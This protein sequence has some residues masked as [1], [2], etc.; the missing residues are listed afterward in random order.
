[1]DCLSDAPSE[2][3]ACTTAFASELG[4]AWAWIAASRSVVRPS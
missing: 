4:E 1:M 2:L 3:N